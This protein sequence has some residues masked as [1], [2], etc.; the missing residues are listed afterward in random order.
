MPMQLYEE[1]GG[2]LVAVRVTGKLVQADYERLVP[3]LDRLIGEHRKLCLLFELTS[4]DGWEP[5]ALCEEVKFD[6]KH[7]ADIERVAI[8]GDSKWEQGMATL[9][10]PFT[11]AA[12]RYFSLDNAAEAWEWWRGQEQAGTLLVP[13]QSVSL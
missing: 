13:D 11:T 10:R 4:F 1:D 2:R 5:A 6:I 3:A 7:F 8:I 12:V 9:Y